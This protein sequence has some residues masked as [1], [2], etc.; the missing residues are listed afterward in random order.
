MFLPSLSSLRRLIKAGPASSDAR[1]VPSVVGEVTADMACSKS[2]P[3]LTK[4][5]VPDAMRAKAGARCFTGMETLWS[6][7]VSSLSRRKMGSQVQ[8][9]LRTCVHGCSSVMSMTS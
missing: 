3:F 8:P 5:L 6:A 9:G 7:M 2:D 4:S 1:V